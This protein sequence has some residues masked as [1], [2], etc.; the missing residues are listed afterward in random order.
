MAQR[1]HHRFVVVLVDV[2][3]DVDVEFVVVVEV[4]AVEDAVGA[5]V[6]S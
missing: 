4:E 1:F 2:V 6:A 3:V 5:A